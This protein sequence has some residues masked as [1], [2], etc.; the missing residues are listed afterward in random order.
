[1]ALPVG[2]RAVPMTHLPLSPTAAGHPHNL[3]LAG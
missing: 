1:M 2:G 3:A